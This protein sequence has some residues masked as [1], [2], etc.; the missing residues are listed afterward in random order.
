[1][2]RTVKPKHALA[3][4]I[5]LALLF[6]GIPLLLRM[7][8][9]DPLLATA[10][11]YY[12]ARIAQSIMDSGIIT[13]DELSYGGRFQAFNPYPYLLAFGAYFIGIQLASVFL[14]LSL[15][16]VSLILLHMILRQMQL[17]HAP[18]IYAL[19]ALT[20]S[21]AFIFAAATSN[22]HIVAIALSLG[23][24]SLF[25]KKNNLYFISSLILIAL[26]SLFDGLL[27][28][29]TLILLFTFALH[30]KKYMQ[31][32]KAV[33]ITLIALWLFQY[34]PLLI[35]HGMPRLHSPVEVHILQAAISD[36]GSPI[37]FS[38]FMLILAL[39]GLLLT[40]RNKRKVY[41]LFLAVVFFSMLSPHFPHLN[42]YL[43]LIF[44]VFAGIALDKLTR[45]RYQIKLMK[46]L[47]ILL[48]F[49]GLIFSSMS[50]ANRLVQADPHTD[51][52]E[53]L[54]YLQEAEDPGLV[55]SDY[56]KGHWIS[57][58]SGF[59]VYTDSYFIYAPHIDERLH[60][61]KKI[62]NSSSLTETR[63]LLADNNIRYV[64]IDEDM[65]KTTFNNQR[66]GFLYLTRN[67]ETFKS[68][69][70]S[71]GVEI[72]QFLGNG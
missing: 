34:V 12:H 36:L 54:S 21:P 4:V 41:P 32:V 47:T 27:A 61:S 57:Y 71:N 11:P 6:S 70:S 62:F 38:P 55:L 25:L 8:N 31:K 68:I 45:M 15:S 13:F 28:L 39:I 56:E 22:S 40:W 67:N 58:A 72:W 23:S 59:P 37:G 52:I 14:S 64:F 43:T 51:A 50:F 9:N 44:S 48:I 69:Y 5:V 30:H 29:L 35:R 63:E 2:I 49:C 3:L 18:A 19:I 53:A 24:I 7:N 60:I 26:A 66:T 33:G 17:G 10:A 42:I 65:K 1:M 16:I 20:L 46:R